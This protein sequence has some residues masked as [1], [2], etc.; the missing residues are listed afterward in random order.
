DIDVDFSDHR[1]D[2]GIDYVRQKY[3]DDHVA[4]IVTFGTFQARSLVR[5][6][7]KTM[8]IE[9]ED[10]HY[11]LEQFPVGANHSIISYI[12]SS[13]EFYDYIRQSGA[14]KTLCA[15]AVKLEG[16]PRHVSTHAAGVVISKDHLEDYTPLMAG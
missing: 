4:Q 3:G 13:N 15:I 10:A 1:R 2:E 12:K 7:I 14:L 5:E 6:L 16:L 11:I 9:E 8:G